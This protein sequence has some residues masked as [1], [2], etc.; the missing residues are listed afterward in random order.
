MCVSSEHVAAALLERERDIAR[1]SDKVKVKPAAIL[2]KIVEG[3]IEKYYATACLLEQP[4]I[5]NDKQTV[6]DFGASKIAELGENIVV[7]RFVRYQVGE[8]VD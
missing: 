7:R 3:T 6:K 1:K 2:D 5:K 4:F 8:S